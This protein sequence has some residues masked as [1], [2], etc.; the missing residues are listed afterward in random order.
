MIELTVSLPAIDGAHLLAPTGLATPRSA[1][2]GVDVDGAAWRLVAD[3][4]SAQ[5]ALW[6][7]P[8]ADRITLRWRYAGHGAPH[9]EAMFT[10]RDN[11]FTRAA[12]ALTDEAR[13]IA[14]QAGGGACGIK[15][16]ADHV[17]GM[18][19]YGHVAR[20]FND[21][22]DAIP[23]L[24]QMTTGSCVDINAYF[25][26][27]CRAAGYQAG[28]VTGYFIPREKR[29]HCDDM[30]C[31]VVT[32][33]GARVQAWDIAHHLKTG[34]TRVAPGL[35]PRPGVRVAMAHSMGLNFPEVGIGDMK[36]LAE[37]VWIDGKGDWTRTDLTISLS[38]YDLLDR[39]KPSTRPPETARTRPD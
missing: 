21:G 25:I 34:R 5:T 15:A 33:V 16:L 14:S 27:V 10:P 12:T 39:S 7:T 37:P 30:H 3:P 11:R 36:L 8:K 13:D 26:A 38:G 4:T 1:P 28:Y 35:N 18:F 20:P 29:D 22:H 19:R 2:V 9:P 32:R 23:Q 31:W 24:C 6:L 17:A